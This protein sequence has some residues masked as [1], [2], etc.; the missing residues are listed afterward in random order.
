[1]EYRRFG[2]LDW[3]VSALGFGVMRMPTKGSHDQIDEKEGTRMIQYAVDHGV[4]YFDTAYPYHGGQSE[5]FLGRALEGRRDKV[6]VATKLPCWE[7]EER[8]DF[9]KYLNEQLA[10]LDMEHVDFYLL[11]GLNEKRWPKMYELGVLDWAEKAMQDGRIGHLGFS[12]HD[13]LSVFKEI[14]DTYDGWTFCQIQYNYMN[15]THQAGTEGLEYAAD[16]GLAVVIMEPLLG[17]KLVNPPEPIQALWEAAEQER[18]APEWALQWLWNKPQVSTVLSGMSTM[19]QVKENIA[20]AERAE[21][22]GLTEA[23]LEI[24]ARVRAR[25]DELCP[26]PC[27]SCRYCMPCPNG[28]DIPGVF[29]TFNQGVMY[30]KMADARR[31]YERMDEEKRASACIACGICEEQCP[32]DIPISEW[33]TVVHEVLGEGQPYDPDACPQL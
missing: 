25:Y 5:P 15:E 18:G 10:R 12:F 17:G 27:T 1:M 20:S 11:H 29:S 14:I 8:G 3:K 22:G 24:I 4:N 7:V 9:D 21:I 6:R 16:K 23:E 32:Q 2:T 28:V 33:M 26:V 13:K 19:E 30:S 31:R